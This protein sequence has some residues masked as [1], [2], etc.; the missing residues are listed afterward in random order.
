MINEG[1]YAIGVHDLIWAAIQAPDYVDHNA[2]LLA[3]NDVLDTLHDGDPVLV[4]LLRELAE[5]GMHFAV[6]RT[7]HEVLVSRAQAFYSAFAEIH[8]AA[9]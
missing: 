6:F 4:P 9:A 8:P 2:L 7:H 1:S 3:C 5:A